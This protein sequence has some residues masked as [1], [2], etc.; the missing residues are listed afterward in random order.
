MIRRCLNRL[1]Q[2]LEMGSSY[3]L[4]CGYAG[5]TYRTFRNWMEK[6]ESAKSGKF[7]HFFHTVKRA[8]AQ[9]AMVWLTQIELSINAGDW[10]AAAWKL[11]Y[12]HPVP[13]EPAESPPLSEEEQELLAKSISVIIKNM[14]A[15]DA[16]AALVLIK[17][18]LA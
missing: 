3:E 18:L 12:R 11:K 16:G 15:G 6:G 13:V 2:A 17:Q 10:R 14:E 4:A 9:A 1:Q 5:I 7:F 8:E